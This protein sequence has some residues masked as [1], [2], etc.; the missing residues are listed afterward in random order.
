MKKYVRK[1]EPV[2]ALKWTGL[3][4]DDELKE[5]FGPY[6]Y[7]FSEGVESIA[8]GSKAEIRKFSN[9]ADADLYINT[10]VGYEFCKIGDYVIKD[11]E[12]YSVANK[13]YFEQNFIEI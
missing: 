4:K 11:G 1:S 13:S 10:S 5:F 3:N 6:I 12:R 2:L 8:F 9:R 7:S